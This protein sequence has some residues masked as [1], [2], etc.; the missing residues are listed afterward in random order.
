MNTETG[1]VEAFSDGVFAIAI[2]LLILEIKIPKPSD[3]ALANQLLRQWPSYFAFLI[4]FAFIGV[5]WINHHRLFTHIKRCNNTLMV[6]NLLLLLGVTIV[7]FPTA[8]LAT[9]IGFSDQRTAALLYN[10]VYVFI[11]II[12]NLLWRYAVSRNH[13]LLGKEVDKENVGRISKQY[14]FGPLLYL[15]CAALAWISVPASLG[16]NVLL[17]TFF[18]LPPSHASK[19]VRGAGTE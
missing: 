1:R 7:P 18:A 16:A 10:G 5:M 9:H 11:A 14:A 6:L 17:A 8:V 4:S 3:G 19:I 13:H 12:F 15:F 2:T